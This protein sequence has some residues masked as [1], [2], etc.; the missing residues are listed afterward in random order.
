MKKPHRVL[1]FA[2]EWDDNGR[3]KNER[4]RKHSDDGSAIA[5]HDDNKVRELQ[6]NESLRKENELLSQLNKA[7]ANFAPHNT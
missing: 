7:K 1:E 4:I 6:E 5:E 3:R 2:L